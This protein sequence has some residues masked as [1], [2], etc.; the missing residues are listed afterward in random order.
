[1]DSNNEIPL[2][3]MSRTWGLVLAAVAVHVI[4]CYSVIDIHFQSPIISGVQP[5]QPS[6]VAPAKRLVLLVADGAPLRHCG[7]CSGHAML[8]CAPACCL[9]P[10]QWL[11]EVCTTLY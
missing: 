10:V 3:S 7:A 6:T 5:V 1:M 2:P 9:N 8:P 11:E 4:L